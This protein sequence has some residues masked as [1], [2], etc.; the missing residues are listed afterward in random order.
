MARHKTYSK[1]LIE[2]D[3]L[4]V[5]V[6][7][8][9]VK[10]LNLRVYPGEK[11]VRVSVPRRVNENAVID[12]IKAKLPW[13]KKHLSK[14]VRLSQKKKV[15]FTNGEEH[16]V[17]GKALTLKVVEQNKAPEVYINDAS[18]LVIVVR[19]ETTRDKKESILKEWYR[20]QLKKEIPQLINKWEPVMGVSV[21]EFGVKKM[22]TRWGT[23]NIRAGRIWLN[24]ELARKR[25]ELLEYVVVH[26]MVHLL[27]R[28]H[29]KRFYG[30]MTRFL[31]N[32]KE[33]RNE[34]NGRSKISDC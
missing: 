5:Q 31:P 33:H 15:H 19:P 6:T 9:N 12:F 23:C 30:F 24:L 3:G 16:F 21:N 2:V 8:K 10:N 28:L 27:E 25:P 1:Q 14:Q 17:W 22:K 4:E 20:E 13:I 29:S 18:F 26:E 32:W 11:S 34:L 7:R